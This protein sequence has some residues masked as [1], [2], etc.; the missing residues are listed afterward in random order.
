MRN[1]GLPV[2][3][4]EL[5]VSDW[6][7]LPQ[8]VGHRVDPWLGLLLASAGMLELTNSFLSSLLMFAMG[9]YLLHAATHKAMDSCR[10]QFFWEG[11]GDH[12]KYHMV[13]WPTVCKLKELWG[14]GILNTRL[15]NL[16]LML[17]WIWKLYQNAEGLWA[18]LI[19]AKYLGDRD[20]FDKEVPIHGSQFWKAIRKIKWHFKSGAKHKVHN[21]KHTYFW[22]DWWT[23]NAPLRACFPRLFSFCS[24]PFITVQGGRVVGVPLGN[25]EYTFAA[26]LGSRNWL[27]GT[28][29]AVR[30]RAYLWERKQMS[31]LGPLNP[32]GSTLPAPCTWRSRREQS[33][34]SFK[35]V[36]RTRVPPKIKMFHW[37]LMRGRL[38]SSEQVAKHMGPS[39]GLC[40]LWG[41]LEDCNHIFF[42]MPTCGFHVGR[43][44]GY[45][46]LRLESGGGRRF[47]GNSSGPFGTLP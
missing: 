6:D 8:K 4:K 21:G 32:L 44:T 34:T 15:M 26:I 40:S 10:A 28:T 29:F 30:S 16:A 22:L 47:H 5:R 33:V 36:W 17:K 31:Y 46:A 27:N 20:L 39:N 14:L 13:D 42:F 11:T 23:R 35:D 41:V 25:G 19:R 7:F 43:D 18:D 9:I 1:L 24:N 45:P 12:R 3:D 38:P 2:S 37:Q